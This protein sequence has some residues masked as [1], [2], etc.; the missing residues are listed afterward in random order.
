MFYFPSII[1]TAKQRW[2]R[3]VK[4]QQSVILFCQSDIP[5]HQLHVTFSCFT[6]GKSARNTPS[7]P[8]HQP[9]LIWSAVQGLRLSGLFSIINSACGFG[10]SLCFSVL[11]VWKKVSSSLQKHISFLRSQIHCRIC[12]WTSMC[13][14]HSVIFRSSPHWQLQNL[15]LY[16]L[17]KKERRRRRGSQSRIELIGNFNEEPSSSHSSQL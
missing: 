17:W 14:R 16:S 6:P 9:F 5:S 11:F 2:S 8:S 1:I 3:V 4:L 7:S 15:P 10:R 12:I 13:R